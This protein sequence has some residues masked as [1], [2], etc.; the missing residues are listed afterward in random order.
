MSER[1]PAAIREVSPDEAGRRLDNYL[2]TLLGGVPRALVYRIIRSGE[3]RVNGRRAQAAQRVEAG[4]KVRVPPFVPPDAAAP[5][6]GRGIKD[7]VEAAVLFEDEHLMALNKPSGL[8]VHG[9]S[10]LPFG[11]VDV[12]RAIRPDEPRIELVHRLDRETSGCLLLAKNGRTLREL[13]S[14]LRDGGMRKSYLALLW[15]RLPAGAIRCA[16]P[17]QMVPDGNGERHAVVSSEG[18]DARSEFRGRQW[19]AEW[20]LTDV[21]IDTGRTHQIRAHA[22]HLGHPVAAD[23]RYAEPFIYEQGRGLGLR[24]MFLHAAVLEF[25]H[26]GRRQLEAPLPDD[27]AALVSRLV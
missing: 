3:V 20:T 6:I 5:Q 13:H 4:D 12:V 8:A 27:L 25:E 19:Y 22:A 23:A 14:Q 26:Q 16:A 11:V 7:T 21:E 15:G 10:G 1:Q 2:T 17:L 24:R 9:G 18:N